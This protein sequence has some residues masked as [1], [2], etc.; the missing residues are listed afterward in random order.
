MDQVESSM[1]ASY[2]KFMVCRD[3]KTLGIPYFFDRI[4]RAYEV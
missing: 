2:R 4:I 3:V 1:D